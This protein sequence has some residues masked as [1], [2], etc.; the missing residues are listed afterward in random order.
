MS[1]TVY[2]IRHHGPGSAKSLRQ[3]LQQNP[4]DLLLVEG[5]PGADKL[6]ENIGDEGMIPPLAILVYNPKD[7]TQ[8]AYFPFAKFSPEWQAIK[9]A[10]KRNIPTRFMD[11]PQAY[12]Y[13]L[14]QAAAEKTQLNIELA[15]KEPTETAEEHQDLLHDPLGYIAKIA[16]YA[17]SE[18]WW[19]VTFERSEHSEEIFPAIIE[20]MTSLRDELKRPTP[21]RELMREA[22]MR[23]TLRKAIKDG[24]QNIAIVCGAWHSPV[25]HNLDAFKASTDN[26]LLKGIKKI[27][28]KATWVPWTYDR[29]SRQSGYGAGVVS[30]AWYELL[31]SHKKEVV[32]RWMTKVARLFRKEDLDASSAHVIEAVR[33]AE[34]L[35]T[36]RE[37]QVPGINELYEAAVSIFC[38][39]Y[40]TQMELI[41]RQL[42]IG[43]SIGKVPDS[44]PLIPLQQDLEK[45]IKTA[46][47]SKDYHSAEA[48]DKKL[49]LRKDTN[50]LAS[51]LLHRLNILGIPWGTLRK[52]SQYNTGGFSESWKLHW[53]PDYAIRIIEAGMWGNRVDQA[54]IHKIVDTSKNTSSLAK[55][56]QLVDAALKAELPAAIDALVKKLTN[57]AALSKDV[58][59]LM[60]T[61]EPLVSAMRYGSTRNLAFDALASLIQQ[62]IPRICIGLP[63]ACIG[64]NEEAATEVF[65]QLQKTNRA[66]NLLDEDAYYEQWLEALHSI[67]Q[68]ES[69]N[70][71]LSG[72]CARILFDKAILD[73]TAIAK[74]MSLALSQGNDTHKSANWLEGFLHGSGLLLIHNPKLWNIL[75]EWVTQLS[76]ETL[77]DL[78]PLLRRTFAAFSAP[79][80]QKMLQLAKGGQI[81]LQAKTTTSV[82][83]A[84][85]AQK[86]MPTLKSLLGIS[87][88]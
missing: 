83:Q 42:I 4:P 68:M 20:L 49:D 43:S 85:R 78:L 25:L 22:F 77:Q 40:T 28:T 17:D 62:L 30:P 31:F 67:S 79:E 21:D 27:N 35:A 71:I 11:L 45:T 33:L 6:I 59:H 18:R 70:N 3:A 10:L 76:L 58:F 63:N 16:G 52:G 41:E 57:L 48:T 39:G 86:L 84:E 5:P 14:Q 44:I 7:L 15:T 9:F 1:F 50:L 36:L 65:E 37:L 66:I 46:R 24:Y 73:T 34:T 8:A 72:A 53:R 19:E 88:Q 75:D 69:I 12:H 13:A 54:A 81:E 61:L 56:S 26:A 60:E 47:L 64:L 82:L 23:K 51:H 32:I 80:R 38:D 55:L 2:G 29:I 87:P 74:Q